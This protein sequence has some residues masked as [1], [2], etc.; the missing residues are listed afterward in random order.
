MVRFA[1]CQQPIKFDPADD[2]LLARIAKAVGPSEFWLF[3]PK[4]FTGLP[5]GYA[6]DWRRLPG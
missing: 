4:S 5:S 3:S 6:I 1:L 2:V